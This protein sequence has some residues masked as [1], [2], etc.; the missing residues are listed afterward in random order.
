VEGNY[1]RYSNYKERR[2]RRRCLGISWVLILIKKA[3]AQ[4]ERYAGSLI[5]FMSLS[6]KRSLDMRAGWQRCCVCTSPNTA[7]RL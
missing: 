3:T 7:S 1:R 5:G 4:V 2:M 6:G